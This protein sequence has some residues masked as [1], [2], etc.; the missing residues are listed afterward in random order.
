LA[1]EKNIDIVLLDVCKAFNAEGVSYVLIGGWAVIIHGFPRLT[2]DIDFLIERS[3]ENTEKMKKA[4]SKVFHD[5]SIEDI[6]PTD[7]ADYSVVRYVSPDG[8]YID[9]MGK[10][11]EAASFD[12]VSRHIE[13]FEVLDT[14][15]PVLNVEMLAKLKDTLRDKDRM[16]LAF[17]KEK[18]KIKNKR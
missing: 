18:L 11:G 12:T 7:I 17:L 6:K 4:L 5:E 14:E 13:L 16:D 2:N 9:L 3:P 10:I 8:V 15:I 1:T